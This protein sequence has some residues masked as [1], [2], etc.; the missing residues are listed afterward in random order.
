MYKN[1]FLIFTDMKLTQVKVYTKNK[2]CF[3]KNDFFF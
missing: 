3:R 1:K 2:K